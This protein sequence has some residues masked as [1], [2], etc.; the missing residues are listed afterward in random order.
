MVGDMVSPSPAFSTTC[1]ACSTAYSS[2]SLRR[3][4]TAARSTVRSAAKDRSLAA[5]GTC[6]TSTTIFKADPAIRRPCDLGVH[7]AT[8]KRNTYYIY[9]TR[10]R[11][12]TVEKTN[13]IRHRGT[14]DE[15]GTDPCGV[16]GN[17]AAIASAASCTLSP[18]CGRSFL[19][20]RTDGAA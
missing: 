6:F 7:N 10:R 17:D 16:A 8:W 13:R 9:Q 14:Y 11:V 15:A 19:G 1:S 18:N 5:S 12:H 4:S 2:S 20:T 3:P